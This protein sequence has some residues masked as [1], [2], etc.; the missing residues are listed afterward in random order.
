MA[1]SWQI[2][3]DTA[4]NI[5]GIT[6]KEG[7]FAFA[8]D[9]NDVYIG[10]S[11]AKQ[12][13]GGASGLASVDDIGDVTI[14]TV[15]NDEL[16]QYDS[17]TSKWINQTFTEAGILAA[18]GTVGLTGN[19]NAGSHT[20]QAQTL[21]GATVE[22]AKLVFDA[23]TEVTISS[24]AVTVTQSAHRIDTEGDAESDNLDTINGGSDGMV[25]LVRAENAAHTVVVKD[26]TGNIEL[27]GSDISLDDT[28]QYVLLL[29]DGTLSKWLLG[30]NPP[31]TE[32]G[33]HTLDAAEH[34]DVSAITEAQGQVLFY[35]TSWIAL[36][37]G[38]ANQG[39][40][41][42]GAA[43]DP[44]WGDVLLPDGS[45]TLTANWDVGP[46][47][48]RA[49]AFQ[50]D[51]AT[52]VAPLQ[53]ASATL[54]AN[55]NADLLDGNEASAFFVGSKFD[56]LTD[57]AA[58]TE[59][60]GQVIYWDGS[61][62]NALDP[63]DSG[64]YLKCQG[65]GANPIWD[66]PA[67]AGDLLADGTMP[68][69]ADWDV[70]PYKITAEQLESDVATSTAPL[71][72]A[73]Q[74]VVANLNADKVDSKDASDLVLVDGT[75]A[76]TANWD[77]G[78]YEIRAL[79]FQS[80]QATGTAPLT[81]A[82]TTVVAN[83]NASLLEGNAA[84]AFAAVDHNADH[85]RTGSDEMDGDHLDI[86]YTPSNYTPST[87]PA[88][89]AHVDDLTA[90]IAGIDDELAKGTFE[91]KNFITTGGGS[92]ISTGVADGDLHLPVCTIKAVRL[93][94]DQPGDIVVDIWKDTYANFPPT[95]ADSITAS[96][97]PTLSSAQK[98]EDTTLSGWTTSVAEG[99]V[100]KFNVDSVA[101]ITAITVALKIEVG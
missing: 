56:D 51:I 8:T 66:T 52:G 73:S 20:I 72:V 24:G 87:T 33:N 86:D 92:V 98:Y 81:V 84:A 16:L 19:W 97:V 40:L 69:T 39:L 85:E 21:D 28:D 79:K 5:A 9:T 48:V 6:L 1:K 36:D 80:D 22:A 65:A 71:I 50:S 18:D 41:T 101:T 23:T 100:L 26:A 93:T 94:A 60:Q 83:L 15:A 25:L 43:A 57:V 70:G 13:V 55:L 27:A 82:S 58:I 30:A 46:Y 45:V 77:A 68:L 32:L 62:W 99:D 2:R 12:L 49:S 88:E 74:T 14:T 38:T 96:A 59:A 44:A 61:D 63:G 76:L 11:S 89:A 47:Q 91:W 54:V 67:G 17:G 4:A 29:Y 34:T 64:K 10:T 42:G 78:P 95:D 53:V 7:E 31:G 75:Q 37:P 35:K 90:H 3:R